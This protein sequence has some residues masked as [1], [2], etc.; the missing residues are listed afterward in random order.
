MADD[1]PIDMIRSR[2]HGQDVVRNDSESERTVHVENTPPTL[3]KPDDPC[4]DG[5]YGWVCVGCNAFINGMYTKEPNCPCPIAWSIRSGVHIQ[6][7]AA[8][9]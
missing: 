3:P 1:I 6:P 2:G 8:I 5:G 4:P 9:S 7:L